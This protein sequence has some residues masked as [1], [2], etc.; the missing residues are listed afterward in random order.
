[1]RETPLLSGVRFT[2]LGMTVIGLATL[3][4]FGQRG[5]PNGGV[6]ARGNFVREADKRG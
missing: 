3:R 5:N 2:P 1:M 4:D 6:V